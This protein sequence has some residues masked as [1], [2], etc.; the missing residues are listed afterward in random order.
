M[1]KVHRISVSGYCKK[2]TMTQNIFRIL[3]LVVIIQFVGCVNIL[4]KE[5][6]S[7]DLKKTSF[8]DSLWIEYATAIETKNI[9]YL[10]KNSFDIIQCVDCILD[11]KSNSEYYYSEILF[12]GY[13]DKLMHMDSLTNREFSTFMTDSIIRINYNIEWKL[14]PEGAYGLVFTF[15]KRDERF[16]F[17][18]MFTIP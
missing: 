14:A 5:T 12:N 10:I 16:K 6:N 3:G 17:Y 13:L 8:A 9:E 2:K 7:K 1:A 15:K 11:N 4:K 18:G